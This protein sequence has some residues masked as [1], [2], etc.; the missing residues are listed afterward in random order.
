MSSYA[1]VEAIIA[2]SEIWFLLLLQ[3]LREEN[4]VEGHHN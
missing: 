2:F 1:I 3:K 4:P